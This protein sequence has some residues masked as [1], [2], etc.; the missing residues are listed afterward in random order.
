MKIHIW[1]RKHSNATVMVSDSLWFIIS[2]PAS[3]IPYTASTQWIYIQNTNWS[4]PIHAT[5][6]HCL[7]IDQ[8]RST[9]ITQYNKTENSEKVHGFWRQMLLL[10]PNKKH[11][12]EWYRSSDQTVYSK[13]HYTQMTTHPSHIWIWKNCCQSVHKNMDTSRQRSCDK[14]QPPSHILKW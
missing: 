4:E 6:Q 3:L 10:T 5:A 14:L 7:D 9:L 12:N 8:Y 1:Q 2:S 11:C 13:N